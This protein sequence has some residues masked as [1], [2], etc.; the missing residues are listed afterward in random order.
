MNN[1]K[2]GQIVYHKDV[3][4]YREPLKIVGLR[5]NEIEVE[6]DFS[7]MYNIIQRGTL[8]LNGTSYIYNY[9]YKKRCRELTKIIKELHMENKSLPEDGLNSLINMVLKL[10]EDVEYNKSY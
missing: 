5:E 7:G 1:L 10:T 6:G 9:S 2:L 3:Y 4:D 8:P